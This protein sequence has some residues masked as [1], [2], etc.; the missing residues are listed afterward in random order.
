MGKIF[1]ILTA[2]LFLFL[3]SKAQFLDEKH[4]PAVDLNLSPTQNSVIH[5][6]HNSI[7]NPKLN[8]NINPF[9]N[10]LINPDKVPAIN[11]KTNK[12]LNPMENEEMNPM[13][14]IYMSPKFEHWHGLY[15]FDSNNALI[16]YVTKYSQDIMIQFD[17]ESNWTFFY[18]RT[19]K[20]TYNQFNLTADWTG[21]FLCYDSMSG[22]NLFDNKCSW[23]G[24]HIK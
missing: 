17:K 6:D 4:N 7:I 10:G 19:A 18:V 12:E 16:G 5:P 23:T 8:W 2:F 14:S 13:F 3:T 24:M 9:K 22:F 21:N 15:L 20:G 1:T 11:P